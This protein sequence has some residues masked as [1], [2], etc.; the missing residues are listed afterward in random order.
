[1]RSLT[2][3]KLWLL[4]LRS[5]NREEASI[6]RSVVK[7]KCLPVPY[8]ISLHAKLSQVSLQLL[9]RLHLNRLHAQLCSAFQI[10]RTVVD[11]ATLFGI[12]LR[13]LDGEAIDTAFRLAQADEA[14]AHK[15][16]ED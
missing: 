8:Y 5:L 10:Q 2:F 9:E 12:D 6:H 1:M 7:L 16:A 13:D 15:Q 14:G 3:R 4:R 11:E